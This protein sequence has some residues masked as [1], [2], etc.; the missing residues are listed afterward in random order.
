MAKNVR[1]LLLIGSVVALMATVSSAIGDYGD[2]VSE[3]ERA[4]LPKFCW[5]QM[6][7]KVAKGP[8]FV[9]PGGCGPGM[10]HYCPG[11]VDLIRAKSGA[12][13]RRA[14]ALLNRAEAAAN[15]TLD[16]MKNYPNCAI[17]SHV[18]ATKDEIQ[19]LRSTLAP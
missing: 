14:A 2:G 6:G 1:A 19:K 5:A 18:E 8:A 12:D 17:R 16:W 15:Y 11:L 4:L 10:N 9:I 3:I 7:S 13:K